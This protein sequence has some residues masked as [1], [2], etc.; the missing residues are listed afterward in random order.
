MGLPRRKSDPRNG[1]SGYSEVQLIKKKE[2]NGIFLKTDSIVSSSRERHWAPSN[3][4]VVHFIGP[5]NENAALTE[6]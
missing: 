5:F 4:G 2:T 1:F 3:V 6:N